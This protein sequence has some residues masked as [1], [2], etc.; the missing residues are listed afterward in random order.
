MADMFE[1]AKSLINKAYIESEFFHPDAK[2]ERGEYKTVSPIRS[3]S[4]VGSFSIRE[5][6]VFYDFASGDR[7]DIIALMAKRDGISPAQVARNILGITEADGIPNPPSQEKK[8]EKPKIALSWLPIPKDKQPPFSAK[9]D[10]LTLYHVEDKPAFYIV[11]YNATNDPDKGDGRKVIYPVYWT[12]SM[13]EKGL[14]DD[15]KKKR[16]LYRFDP[17]KTVVIVEGEKC[18]HEARQ[19]FPAYSWTTW[20]GGAPAIKRVDFE[21]LRGCHVIIFPDNDSP[22]ATAADNMAMYLPLICKSVRRVIPPMGKPKGWDIADGIAEGYDVLSLLESAKE[23]QSGIGKVEESTLVEPRLSSNRPLT[24]LGNAERFVDMWGHVLRFNIDKNKWLVWSGGR[25]NDYDQTVVTPMIKRTIRTLVID[26]ERQEAFHWAVKSEQSRMIN[27]MVS[28][29]QRERGIPVREDQLDQDPY[30]LNCP[31]GVIDLRTGELKEP[32]SLWLITKTAIVDYEPTA[33]CPM[34]LKFLDE[35]FSED[36]G[37]LNFIQRWIGYSLTADTSAQTFAVFYG[38]GANGKSTLVETIQKIAGDYVKTA[39]P[40]TFIQK[41]SGGIPN[42]IAALR[43][44]RMVLTTETEANAKL[45]EA[46]V[47]SMTGG[48]RVSARYMRGE[49]FEFIPTWKITIS[50]NHRPRI[51]GGDYGI[52]RRVVLVPFSNVVMPERQDPLLPNKLLTESK[53]ILAW[54]VRGAINWYKSGGGRL[55]LQVPDRVYEETQ[56][57]REDED[58]IGRFISC[59]C[60]SS[61]EIQKKVNKNEIPRDGAPASDVFYSFRYWCEKEG[62]ENYAKTTQNMFGRYMR[63]R[64]FVPE[65]GA[66]TRYY[67]GIVPKDE[68]YRHSEYNPTPNNRD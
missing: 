42:D 1:Q 14:P 49:F 30:F 24:D 41:Q 27:S 3:D 13:F 21:K 45:A 5:D 39:P 58:V 67:P 38:I 35:T 26:D 32:D 11:R 9:P 18:V 7:G 56:E 61:Q 31:N 43:G 46:K 10:Y 48:D 20:H 28:L 57:Y 19:Q 68:F 53:G 52:W 59:A 25:W 29:A 64:G 51:S 23:V 65:R 15:I 36:P 22:G 66:A 54:A 17:S 34:F 4:S 50:T 55:G 60:Y 44:A 63:E 6:G 12:G 8:N 2:W 62:E 47:K 37:L 16:P 33:E 40:D